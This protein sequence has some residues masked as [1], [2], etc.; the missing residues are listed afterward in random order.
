MSESDLMHRQE[1]AWQGT[2][3]MKVQEGKTIVHTRNRVLVKSEEKEWQELST[4][5]ALACL[6]RILDLN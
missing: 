4:V 3:D 5:K 1:L 6:L 2:A